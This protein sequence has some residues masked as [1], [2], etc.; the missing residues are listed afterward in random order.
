[1]REDRQLVEPAAA[2]SL[3]KGE[4]LVAV[5]DRCELRIHPATTRNLDVEPEPEL[6]LVAREGRAFLELAFD[7]KEWP[8][9]NSSATART[10]AWCVFKNFPTPD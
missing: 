1:M 8:G 7:L 9:G 5:K 3:G 2:H 6:R 10:S 4:T